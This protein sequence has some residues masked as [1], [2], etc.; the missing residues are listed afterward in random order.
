MKQKKT[1]QHKAV[2]LN[3]L[4]QINLDAAGLDL[5]AEEIYACVPEGRSPSSVRHFGTYTADLQALAGW[6]GVSVC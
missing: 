4:D 6:L 2:D 5:G 1:E 3:S